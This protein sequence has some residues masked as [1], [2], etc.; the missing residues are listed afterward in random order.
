M[1][2]AGYS[3]NTAKTPSKLTNSKSFKKLI[4]QMGSIDAT[5]SPVNT[6]NFRVLVV[7][8]CFL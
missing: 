1:R 5:A 3:I 6:L 2:Y 7:L 4:E 8:H